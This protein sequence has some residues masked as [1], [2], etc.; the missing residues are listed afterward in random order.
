[1]SAWKLLRNVL[2]AA[3]LVWC[4][5]VQADI[6]SVSYGK[7][8]VQVADDCA[9]MGTASGGTKSLLGWKKTTIKATAKK[10]YAF[11]G[12]YLDGELISREASYTLTYDQVWDYDNTY[13]ARFIAARDDWLS[14]DGSDREFYVG[15]SIDYKNLDY[16]FEVDS[17]S[18][19]TI[20]ISGLPSGVKYDSK[21]QR[22]TGAP[23]KRGVYYVTC[24]V[25]NGN[26][27]AQTCIAVWNVG[28]ASNGDY[29][30]IG[31]FNDWQGDFLDELTTGEY[32][33][34][35]ELPK[36]SVTGLPPGLKFPDSGC[37]N[38]R[39]VT[40]IGE[41]LA[42]TPTKSG[43]YTVTFTA[44]ATRRKTVKTIIVRDA[45]STWVDVVSPSSW[46]GSVTGSGVYKYGSTVKL[47]A[48]P[49]KGYYFVGW[50]SDANF[51]DPVNGD[52]QKANDSLLLDVDA[53]TSVYA[54]FISKDED[55]L[56]L[57]FDDVW[58]VDTRYSYDDFSLYVESETAVT[59]TA[60]GLPS[61]VKLVKSYGEHWLEVQDVSKLKP[62]TSV[63]SLTAKTATGLTRTA[64]L[65]IVVPNL[66]SWVFDGLD[67]SDNAYNLTVGV[68]DACVP[69]WFSFGYDEDYK[70][71]ASG[72]P[73]GM[74]YV[75]QDGYVMF[76]GTPS[77][78]GTYTVTLTAK[79]GTLTEKA[80]F[81]IN[82][83][84]LPEYAVGTFNGVLK[85]EDDA[86][87]GTFVL[88][89]AENGKQSVKVV[90]DL[91]TMSLSAPAW[92]CYDDN[93]NPMAF[94][95]KSSKNEYFSFS[96]TTSD[97]VG[98]NCEH[99]LEGSLTWS[100]SSTGGESEIE[101][102]VYA[103]QRNPFGKT[104]GVYDH[105]AA[106]N[107]AESLASEYK[108][109]NMV[110]FWDSELG[111]YKLECADCVYLP[112]GSDGTATL[113][114]NKNGTATISGKMFGSSFSATAT[115]LF[116]TNCGYHESTLFGEHCHA[117]FAP[118]VK[119]KVC[120]HSTS[121][122]SCTTVN[123]LVPILWKPLY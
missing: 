55:R 112:Y 19:P 75:A 12:W 21:L 120:P 10:G 82:V 68:S 33:I 15:E 86:I 101:A 43:A 115:L 116:D 105:P 59:L 117:V 30:D 64:T 45:G 118:V 98:W 1:M 26:G 73:S 79:R 99:Q 113:K 23:A 74:K 54:R 63:V 109:E 88:T 28:G 121:T 66:Q 47:S 29:D 111:G 22:F 69:S 65:R 42:G 57:G 83:D 2:A 34:F 56:E 95:Y 44:S 80:T 97:G 70:V 77:K 90:T 119:M 50:F 106:V 81:T 16:F 104:G 35:C 67:Y 7:V 41:Y 6:P 13:V 39:C 20:S 5:A 36:M 27:Y 85:D 103:A 94:F 58:N 108:S 49:A 4:G 110:V 3:A 87:V 8:Y 52:Y 96:L 91:G 76:G 89:V 9:G 71:T 53:S 48:K 107:V 122:G 84:P 31:L 61:G 72:L 78:A 32:V 24:S 102:S 40:C 51:E 93:G 17:G 100:K 92:N 62:G 11:V 18:A 25:K 37:V 123:Q 60:K 14:V 46:R 38:G 114:M